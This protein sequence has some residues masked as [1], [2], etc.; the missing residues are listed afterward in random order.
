MTIRVGVRDD[1]AIVIYDENDPR[2]GVVIGTIAGVAKLIAALT[3]LV[4][5]HHGEEAWRQA[6][7]RIMMEA[8]ANRDERLN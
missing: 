2:N 8:V 3:A 5:Q 6:R 1:K 7:M 4:T